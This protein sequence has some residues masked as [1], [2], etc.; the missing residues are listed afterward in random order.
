[1]DHAILTPRVSPT[2]NLQAEA[3]SARYRAL[4]EWARSE[5]LAA[6]VTA[7][8][9]DDQAE[10]VLMRLNRGAGLSGLTAM[11]PRA[12]VPGAA[13]IALLRPL[14]GWR[15][16]ELAA[17]VERAGWSAADDPSNHDPR[18]ERVR[19][20]SLL[21]GVPWLDASRIA[22]SAVHLRAAEEGLAWAITRELEEQ[23]TFEDADRAVYRPRAPQAVRFGVVRLLVENL[24]QEG[25]PRGQEVA[26]L[27][28]ALEAGGTAT[29]AGLRAD[30]RDPAAWRFAP[31]PPRR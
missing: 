17:I 3:R 8:H 19:V 28:A 5:G 16:A 18:F 15:R 20:R 2:G 10:T 25:S 21:D 4:G 6:I 1:M 30:G 23:V 14:L 11:R 24:G 7:H 26:R 29:L 22:A 12:L 27:L 31:A 13:D 9:A